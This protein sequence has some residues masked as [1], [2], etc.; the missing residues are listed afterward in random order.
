M[1]NDVAHK[2]W[3]QIFEIIS[4][5]PFLVA[6][7]LQW[8][9]PVSFPRETFTGVFIL[10]GAFL[11]VVGLAFVVL[12]RREFVRHRQPTD[13]GFPTDAI[14]TTG[15]FSI[16]RNPLYLGG[17]C[18]LVGTSV[19]F[20]FPWGFISLLPS[21]LLCH[22]LLIVPEERYLAGKFG[23]D[24]QKYAATVRRWLGRNG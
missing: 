19:A 1:S 14:I 23:E 2:S 10:V 4:G 16:S 9:I 7:V 24:Y 3:W 8:I 11:I 6:L 21:I 20:N 13:P 22:Y 12:A 5:F 17:M 18:I 15:V